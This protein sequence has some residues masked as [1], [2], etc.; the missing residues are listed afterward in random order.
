VKK[1]TKALLL[2]LMTAGME[3]NVAFADGDPLQAAKQYM[4]KNEVKSAVIELKNLLQGAPENA[5]ARLLL[6]EAYVRLADGASAVKEL[7]KA[8]DLKLPKDRWITVLAQAYLLQGQTQPLLDQLQPDPQLPKPV[9][10]KLLAYRGMAELTMKDKLESARE[11]FNQALQN[12]PD[13]VEALLGFAMLEMGRQQFKSAGDYAVQAT[14]K[15]PKNGQAWTLLGEVKQALGENP[16]ALDAYTH[17]VTLQGANV[18]ARLGRAAVYIAMG[19]LVE[20]RKDVEIVKKIAGEL[21]LALYTEGVID[22]QSKKLD[23]A[24]EALTKV[25][26]RTPDHLPTTFLL[27]AIAY[28]KNEL[29]QAEF[30]LSKVVAAVPGNLSAIKLLAATRLKRGSPAEAIS[31]LQPWAEKEKKDAQLYAILGS[32]YLKNK[33][34]DQGISYLGKAAEIAPDMASVRAE[35]GLGKIAA[36]KMDQG[37]EDLRAAGGIDPNLM[38][39]DATI[40]MALVQQKKFDEAIAEATKLK[41]KRKDDPLADNL[42]GAAYLAKGDAEHA[43]Q[44]WESALAIK[45]DYTPASLNLGKLAMSQN[46]PDDAAK[47]YEK[48]LKHDEKN[49]SALIGLAQVAEF[50]K[51]Y[52]KMA[53]LLE[54]ARQK[55]PKE[56]RA[57]IMLTRYYLAQGKMNQALAVASDAAGNNPD[58]L[59]ALQNLGMAQ[60][61][62]GQASNAAASYRQVLAKQP[63]N[64]ELHHQ[65]AQALYKLGDK[66]GAVKEWDEALKLGPEYIPPMLA[67]AELAMQ[68]KRYGDVLKIAD[69]IK[70]KYPKSPLG[71]QLEGDVLLIQKQADKSVDAY[72]K[73]Y[74]MSP[75]SYLARRL[76]TAR[77]ESRQEQAAFSGMRQWLEKAGQDSE[78][79]GMLATALQERGQ[80]KEAVAAYE[81]S[82]EIH[83]DNLVLQNN[84]AWLYQQLGDKRALVFADKLSSAPGIEAKPEVLD[85]VGWIF[86]NH[87]KEEKGLILLQQAAL[88]DARNGQLRYHVAAALAK[89]GKPDEAKKE[90]ERLLKENKSFPDRAAAEELLKGL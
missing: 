68:D 62:A 28:Q 82:Y 8:R 56:P 17:A 85:T 67:K 30:F 21:P 32:A 84:L 83:P 90:L 81:K 45:P 53:S 4:D 87:G 6:G 44:S 75:S 16:A 72:A 12:D 35:L 69:T 34:Y 18:K 66:A 29:E 27:G 20:A 5:E 3:G 40:V 48:I 25:N 86:L 54:D 59:A 22:F 46:K 73:A 70:Q 24:K 15:G 76:F 78:S 63:G 77:I 89:T 33:Q 52:A 51:D 60:M 71:F 47:E 79:W 41:A 1:L 42:L 57:A 2:L 88:L 58:N 11:S 65:L 64:P 10:A 14:A 74:Q 61:G 38:E 37:I 36:G 43:R 19:N 49:L 9:N 26:T 55:N 7:E 50:K 13:N 31:L 23:E 80:I 39:A